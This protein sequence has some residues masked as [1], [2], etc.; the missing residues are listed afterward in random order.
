LADFAEAIEL[1]NG[2][3]KSI[4]SMAFIRMATAYAEL[5]QFCEAATPI[6]T[7][8]ALDPVSRDNSRSQKII[9]DYEQRG[10]CAASREFQKEKFRVRGQKNVVL[11]KAD[12]NGVRGT[13]VLDTGASYVSMR[14]EFADRAKISLADASEINLH[15]A[16]GLAK[17]K[18]SKAAKV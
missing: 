11:V 3:R 1:F 16:N 18:L 7:W 17:G 12:I 9:A 6:Q 14:S 10:N 8:V 5:G 15:T 13:F 2:D 4:N